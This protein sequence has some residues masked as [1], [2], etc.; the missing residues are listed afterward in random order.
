MG[1]AHPR[2]DACAFCVARADISALAL[3]PADHPLRDERL[4]LAFGVTELGQHLGRVLAEF[5]RGTLEAWLVALQTDRRGDAL[6]PA[7]LDHI[8]AVDGVR[9]GERLVD[10]LHW[11]GRKAGSQQPVAERLRLVLG[12]YRGEFRAQRFPIGDAVLVAGK[13]RIATKLFLSDLFRKLAEGAVI[14]DTDEDVV[15]P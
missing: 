9:V 7:L 5:W 12:K 11:A 2:C 6:V 13:A 8:A 15:G 10:L 3:R 1:A 14:A 4:D